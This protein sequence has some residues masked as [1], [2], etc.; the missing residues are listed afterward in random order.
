MSNSK[1]ARINVRV[2]QVL[3]DKIEA[4]ANYLGVLK[5]DIVRMALTAYFRNKEVR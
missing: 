1:E 2:P 4:E 3:K 5:S